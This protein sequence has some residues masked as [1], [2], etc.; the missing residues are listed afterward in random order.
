VGGRRQAAGGV[1]VGHC[2][3][4]G[5]LS[6]AQTFEYVANLNMDQSVDQTIS[7][8]TGCRL[9]VRGVGVRIPVGLRIIT[10]LYRAD[11][12]WALRLVCN[13]INWPGREADHSPTS[14]EVKKTSVP[15]SAAMRLHDRK[16]NP[17]PGGIIGA[18]SSWG[19]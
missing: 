13:G 1:K 7:V 19:I 14:P 17:M 11:R 16:G 9:D 15:H 12:L 5:G 2:K 4:C 10:S 3:K 6:A 18:P 8:A